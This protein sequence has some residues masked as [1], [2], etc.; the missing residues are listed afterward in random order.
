MQ[1]EPTGVF[2]RRFTIAQSEWDRGKSNVGTEP[3]KAHLRKIL[4][5]F[6]FLLTLVSSD[7]LKIAFLEI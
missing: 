4:A 3:N 1:I 5:S 2:S 6:A 7:V